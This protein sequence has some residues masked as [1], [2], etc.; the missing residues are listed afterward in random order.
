MGDSSEQC[1]PAPLG[2]SPAPF[3]IERILARDHRDPPPRPCDGL[4]EVHQHLVHGRPGDLSPA[5]PVAEYCCSRGMEWP[6]AGDSCGRGAGEGAASAANGRVDAAR[7]EEELDEEDEDDER[8]ADSE[9]GS[10]S[11]GGGSGSGAG[12]GGEERKKRPRTAF[13]AAQVKALEAEFERSK[14]LSVS[15]RLH[16]S[17][18]L[19]LTETQIKIWFQNRRTKWKRKYTNDLEVLAQQYYSSMGILAP[20]PI[21]LGDRL[22]V[23]PGPHHPILPSGNPPSQFHH[24]REAQYSPEADLLVHPDQ[25]LADR[26]SGGIVDSSAVMGPLSPNHP[27]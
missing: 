10:S 27:P 15:K 23:H 25:R 16:L 3:S 26:W 18:T 17:K 2:S 24:V 14:Y 13:T 6:G 22:W 19:K 7:M 20:R 5:T 21:F 4:P 12:A 9:D 11:Q 1:T 8:A